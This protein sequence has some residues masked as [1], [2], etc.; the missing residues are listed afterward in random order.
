M[1]FCPL[2]NLASNSARH[3]GYRDP[4][5]RAQRRRSSLPISELF[6]RSSRSDRSDRGGGGG[7]GLEGINRIADPRTSGTFRKRNSCTPS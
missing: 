1:I 7:G 6:H 3:I 4:A 5:S 2:F